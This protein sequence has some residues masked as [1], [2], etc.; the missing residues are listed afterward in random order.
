M[1][2]MAWALTGLTKRPSEG[3]IGFA[4]TTGSYESSAMRDLMR[5]A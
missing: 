3:P 2:N 5:V 4:S 1:R